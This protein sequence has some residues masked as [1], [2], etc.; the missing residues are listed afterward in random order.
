MQHTEEKKLE[1][2]GGNTGTVPPASGLDTEIYGQWKRWTFTSFE[3]QPPPWNETF[4]SYLIYGKETC[5]ST[6]RPH[7]Q[8]YLETHTKRTLGGVV[9][10]FHQNKQTHLKLFVSGGNA[11][12]NQNYCGKDGKVAEFGTPM[13][14]GERNDIHNLRDQVA[15]GRRVDDMML[16]E[17]AE[18]MQRYYKFL[19]E[20]EDIR[21]KRK[22]QE[23]E[24]KC[25]IYWYWGSTGSG[26]TY[27]AFQL[28]PDAYWHN[29]ED[30]GWF[31]NY[32]GQRDMIIDDF[33]G[34]IPYQ[35]LLKLAQEYPYTVKRRNR[36]PMRFKAK[37]IFITCPFHPRDLYKNLN[38]EDSLEQL[39]RRC[40]EI[41]HF[42]KYKKAEPLPS[43]PENVP[44]C[45]LP[46]SLEELEKK[47]AKTR[48]QMDWSREGWQ[49]WTDVQTGVSSVARFK[50]EAEAIKT[51]EEMNQININNQKINTAEELAKREVRDAKAVLNRIKMDRCEE[52]A[53]TL[54][55]DISDMMKGHEV[56]RTK[57]RG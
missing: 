28:A 31:D 45:I 57:T 44:L 29:V 27:A 47:Y 30:S 33:R 8:G 50:S 40:A 37:R 51:L 18:H 46:P 13:K 26:K 19:R 9:K 3:E 36:P 41:K 10:Y 35:Q 54:M 24:E 32:D 14:Q 4:L 2:A 22:P 52:M 39:Y 56:Q 7:W 5:P 42:T 12:Q 15:R 43:I 6:G 16:E 25:M 53:D 20:V 23:A 55:S 17:K 48:Y 49:S 1:V 38:Q 21:E 34:E 11:K